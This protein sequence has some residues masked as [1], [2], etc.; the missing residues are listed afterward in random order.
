VLSGDDDASKIDASTANLKAID[1]DDVEGE[2][3]SSVEPIAPGP[4]GSN[5][6]VQTDPS[7]TDR[8]TLGAP[9]T[10]GHKQKHPPTVPKHKQTKTSANQVMAQIELPP[11][12][13]P[14]S[15]LDLVVIEIIFGRLFKAFRRTSQA[16]GTR[17]SNG[18]ETQPLKKKKRLC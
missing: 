17:S 8:A 16:A 14:T 2:G 4:I 11:Y 3:A 12:R 15:P 7:V 1:D 13:G 6:S 18:G 9:S 5:A 10:G